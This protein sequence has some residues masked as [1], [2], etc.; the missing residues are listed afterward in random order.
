MDRKSAG[1]TSSHVRH[2]GQH[3]GGQ[4][5]RI[6]AAHVHHNPAPTYA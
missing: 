1:P 5:A 3:E 6:L 4:D 2:V